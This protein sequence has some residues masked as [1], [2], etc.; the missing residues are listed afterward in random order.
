MSKK[1]KPYLIYHPL[2]LAIYPL[3]FFYSNNQSEL[4]MGIIITPIVISLVCLSVLWLLARL[5]LRNWR[6]SSI[7]VSLI[8]FIFFSYGHV[9]MLLKDVFIPIGSEIVIGPHKILLPLVGL[10]IGFVFLKLFKSKSRWFGLNKL[11]NIILLILLLGQ[12]FL[13]FKQEKNMVKKTNVTDQKKTVEV[14][15]L[16]TD[17]PDIYYIILD[18]YARADILEEL[19]EYDNSEFIE[20]LEKLGFFVSDEAS[21]NYSQTFLSLSSSLNMEYVNYFTD[22]LGKD[23]TSTNLAHDMIE[24]SSVTRFLKQRGYK[25]INFASGWGPTDQM[26]AADVNYMNTITF[27]FLGQRLNLNEFY[28]VFLQT[29][30]LIPF[31]QDSLIDQARSNILYT[32]DKL[33]EI[34]YQRGK[35]MVIAHL[36]SPHPPYLF[37]E[38]GEEIP[39]TVLEMAGES[40]SDR[41][42]YLKQLKFVNKRITNTLEKIIERSQE[43]PLIVLQADHGPASILGHPHKW[44]RPHSSEGIKERM[45][46]LYAYYDP[47]GEDLFGEKTTPVNTFRLIFDKYFETKYGRLDDVSYFSD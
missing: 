33:T 37:D 31:I 8:L 7:F 30:A 9:A 41:E 12:V 3:L 36:N 18:A 19:Y 40:F 47:E 46:I 38:N 23:S 43:K 32:F 16:Y 10:S 22:Q 15:D 45:S 20:H 4:K 24:D 29:T 34:P 14:K 26:M 25:I 11:L 42:N 39:E 28:I 6:T 27:E 5:A 35:K 17:T 2:I 1:E 44:T 13:I 21:S